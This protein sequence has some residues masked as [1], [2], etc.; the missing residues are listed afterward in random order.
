[1]NLSI[2]SDNIVTNGWNFMKLWPWCGNAPE[3]L[4]GCLK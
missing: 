4:L 3:V 2:Q 1:M